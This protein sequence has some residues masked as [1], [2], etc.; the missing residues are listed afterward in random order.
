M[1]ENINTY[2]D[3]I[4]ELC[5]QSSPET[6]R[7]YASLTRDENPIHLDAD[8]A[9]RTPFGAPIA[10]GTMSLNLLLQAISLTPG[11]SIGAGTLDLRFSAP[12]KVGQKITAGG[13]LQADGSY[14][15]SVTA[16]DGSVT[17]R[18]IFQPGVGT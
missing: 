13:D 9:A 6:A 14:A 17:L 5:L 3:R 15:V 18:G 11:L 16:D 10:H 12:V 1:T 8:F 2:P 4:T 7:A